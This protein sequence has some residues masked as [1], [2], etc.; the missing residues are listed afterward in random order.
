MNLAEQY[1]NLIRNN[2]LL[3]EDNNVRII[4]IVRSSI[5]R[6]MAEHHNVAIYCYGEHTH[7]LMTDFI[8]QLKNVKYIVDNGTNRDVKAGYAI[9]RDIEIGEYGFDGIIIS[10]YK[11]MDSISEQLKENHPDVAILNIYKEMEKCGVTVR[12]EYYRQNHPFHHYRRINEL[13]NQISKKENVQT[14]NLYKK[15]VSEYVQIKDFRTAIAKA[16]EWNE[17]SNNKEI[18]KLLDDLKKVYDNLLTTTRKI[19]QNHVLML[20]LDG[21]RRKDFSQEGM[22]KLFRYFSNNGMIF[23]DA[24]SYST[25][26]YESLLPVYSSNDD[27]R[28]LDYDS[29]TIQDELCPFVTKATEQNRKIHFYTDVAK[30]VNSD[31][32]DYKGVFQTATEKLWDFVLDA[33]KE[34]LGLYYV[35]IGYESHYAFVNP[36]TKGK[37]IAEGTGILFDFLPQ[38]GGK[39]RTDYVSQHRDS[40]YYLDDVLSPIIECLTCSVVLFADHGNLVLPVDTE[41]ETLNPQCLTC[42]EDWIQIPFAVLSS[43]RKSGKYN[44]LFS[45]MDLNEVLIH[46][47]DDQQFV[48]QRNRWIKVGRSEIY[49]P[50]FHFLYEKM[51]QPHRLLAFEGFLFESGE[52]LVIYSDKSVELYDRDNDKRIYD[53][54]RIKI[55]FLEIQDKVTVCKVVL[56]RKLKGGTYE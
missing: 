17:E 32:I 1:K 11:Y 42:H 40:L 8:F 19:S 29:I 43:E 22:P 45:L 14:D 13:Q 44:R 31:R 24:Y 25:S 16:E 9:I 52:K 49:N 54:E 48:P 4:D 34:T 30:F 46:L 21:L 33:S 3:V 2:N 6:F 28:T 47:M 35:H 50:D 53:D 5:E 51:G 7:M 15:L 55:L 36:Y 27:M 41:L 10:S 37:L 18:L 26:T 23:R 39:L 56:N 20:C 12:C 38:K